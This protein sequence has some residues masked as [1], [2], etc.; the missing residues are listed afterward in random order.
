MKRLITIIFLAQGCFPSVDLPPDDWEFG[1]VPQAGETRERDIVIFADRPPLTRPARGG[2]NDPMDGAAGGMG[3]AFIRGDG[4]GDGSGGLPGSGGMVSGDGDGDGDG[5]GGSIGAGDGDGDGDGDAPIDESCPPALTC[6]KPDGWG[7]FLCVRNGSLPGCESTRT[8]SDCEAYPGTICTGVS[9]INFSG[10]VCLKSCTPD[11]VGGDGDGDGDGDC[12]IGALTC[13]CFSDGTCGGAL[14]CIAG[15]CE[16]P[17][18][19]GDGDGDTPIGDGDWP[20][21]CSSVPCAADSL[22]TDKYNCGGPGIQCALW[23][24]LPSQCDVE[25]LSLEEAKANTTYGT[26]TGN[27]GIINPAASCAGEALGN[28]YRVTS[29]NGGQLIA[30][31]TDAT[32][33]CGDGLVLY[34]R[35]ATC[36]VE[37]GCDMGARPSVSFDVVIGAEYTV[38]IGH[39]TMSCPFQFRISRP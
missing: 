25:G 6:E 18:L 32:A 33:E 34:V 39:L 38:M 19:V 7:S 36:D 2:E 28:A 21:E 17:I 29:P 3:G 37:L 23:C 27:S 26:N 8:N 15:I 16:S 10:Y 14:E 11:A 4:D 9:G 20:A 1:R 24:C 12:T 31:V 5:S 30:A 35:D 13:A 22:Q